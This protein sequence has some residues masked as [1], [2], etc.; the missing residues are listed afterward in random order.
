[1]I[2]AGGG[3]AGAAAAIRLSHHGMDVTLCDVPGRAPL[4]GERLAGEGTGAL[5]ALGVWTSFL[6]GRHFPSPGVVSAWGTNT[7]VVVDG[8]LD[9]FGTAWHVDRP[10]FDTMLRDRAERAGVRL[11]RDARVRRI[12]QAQSGTWIV[13]IR[14]QDRQHT[15]VAD[16]VLDARGR[17]R[18]DLM[19]RPR[20]ISGDRLLATVF[21]FD[22]PLRAPHS[23][24]TLIESCPFGWWYSAPLPGD[25]ASV[26]FFT[27]SDLRI[28]GT[29]VWQLAR[30]TRVE[31]SGDRLPPPH[32]PY[33]T[34]TCPAWSLVGDDAIAPTLLPVG[35]AAGAR[36]PLSGSGLCRSLDTAVQAAD[37]IAAFAAGHEDALSSYIAGLEASA[38]SYDKERRRVY[39][40]EQRWLDAPFWSRRNGQH[41]G[42][43]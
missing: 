32:T 41:G 3:P 10:A 30:I 13:T 35:D 16:V 14:S 39:A 36:D 23:Q 5:E 11:L 18:K 28:T 25:R 12:E 43:R 40:L 22:A 42:A 9:P 19:G 29:H 24:W 8:L 6:S 15:C 21:V 7:P 27:D 26:A 20:S 4:I 17:Q 38:A 37:S 34:M 31:L 2:V 1:V 33:V